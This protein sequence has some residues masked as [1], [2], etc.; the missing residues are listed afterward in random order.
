MQY[1]G[2]IKQWTGEDW[3]NAKI[4]LSTAQPSLGGAP[5]NLGQHTIKFSATTYSRN[6]TRKTE[7]RNEFYHSN[8]DIRASIEAI[9]TSFNRERRLSLSWS[10]HSDD[11][12]S[13]QG[14][15]VDV[16]TAEVGG[17]MLGLIINNNAITFSLEYLQI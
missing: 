15:M 12:D 2:H 7:E 16:E 9:P 5:P 4:T 10:H 8:E 14:P 13:F 17:S 3:L 6:R 1:F 11:D